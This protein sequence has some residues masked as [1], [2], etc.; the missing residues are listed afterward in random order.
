MRDFV[1]CEWPVPGVSHPNAVFETASLGNE[2]HR[3][4]ITKEGRLVRH[5]SEEVGVYKGPRF[6]RDVELPIHGDCT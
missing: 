4:T 5:V 3:Y 1:Q 6:T 2:G